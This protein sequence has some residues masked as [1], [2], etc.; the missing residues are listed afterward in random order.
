MRKFS[1]CGN[2]FSLE[3]IDWCLQFCISPVIYKKTFMFF[4]YPNFWELHTLLHI[5]PL[6]HSLWHGSKLKPRLKAESRVYHFTIASFFIGQSRSG[7]SSLSS[8]NTYKY[9]Q[10]DVYTFDRTLHGITVWMRKV[11]GWIHVDILPSCVWQYL[12]LTSFQ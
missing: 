12:S 8:D 6:H 5:F 7:L 4:P 9:V 1:L 11:T 2:Q 3:I 10:R